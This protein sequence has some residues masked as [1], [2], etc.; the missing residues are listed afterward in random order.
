MNKFS[1]TVK[2]ETGPV[3]Y[4]AISY[5]SVEVVIDAIVIFGVCGVTVR[6]L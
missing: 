3:Q 1:V 2:T 4:S 6:P 5:A